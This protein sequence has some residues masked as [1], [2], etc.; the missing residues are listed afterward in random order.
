SAALQN[1]IIAAEWIEAAIDAHTI[2][3]YVRDYIAKSGGV[4]A[5]YMAG[6]DVADGDGVANDRNALAI[7]QWIIVRSVEE[8][9]DR[10]AGVTARKAIDMCRERKIKC[11]YDPIGVGSNVKNEYNR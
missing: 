8:W 4:P 1:L 7:R 2:I 6:L 11:Q 5:V 3:P 10:D 9:G